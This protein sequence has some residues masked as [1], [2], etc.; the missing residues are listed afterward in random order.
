MCIENKNIEE[1]EEN[2]MQWLIDEIKAGH[3]KFI[4]ASTHR[5]H[6]AISCP[7]GYGKSGLIFCDMLY[8]IIQSIEKQ[9]KLILNLCTPIIKLCAQQGVDFIEL[10]EGV[11]NYYN[12]DKEKIR[13]F[14]NNSADA[15]KIYQIDDESIFNEY[16]YGCYPFEKLNSYFIND[17]NCDIAIIISCNRSMDKFINKFNNFTPLNTTIVTYIDEAHTISVNIDND[18]TDRID[19]ERLCGICSNLYLISATNRQ[20]LVKMVNSF[21][22]VNDDS[23]IHL[24]T[25]AEAIQKNIIC[26]PIIGFNKVKDGI[27]TIATCKS[28]MNQVRNA[29]NKIHHKILITCRDTKHLIEL[30]KQLINSGYKVFST[31]YKDG[32][33]M[34]DV[35]LQDDTHEFDNIKNFIDAIKD[36][37]DHCFILH[38]KQMISGIDIPCITDAIISKNDTDNENSY[39]TII[40]TIGRCLRLGDERTHPIEE[41][42]KKC[43]NI[44]FVTD[45]NNNKVNENLS[46]FFLAYY[47]AN[48]IRFTQ[49]F[50]KVKNSTADSTKLDLYHK[51]KTLLG[52]QNY[53]YN[54]L[55]LNIEEYIKEC[56][57]HKE[58]CENINRN[59]MDIMYSEDMKYIQ[60][61]YIELNIGKIYLTKYLENKK[62]RSD[63][64]KL[65]KKYGII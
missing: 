52:D 20:E 8:H 51:E 63:I 39:I 34:S 31:S 62:L 57:A 7:T 27:I 18:D 37:N 36:L 50:A 54:E 58:F 16:D 3:S 43:A 47:E 60:E 46:K 23:Y 6:G 30:R 45:L 21:N 15:D 17:T 19:L 2:K 56:K 29:N 49:D 64:Q 22:G 13:I 1:K 25:P 26:S 14:N 41:R 32:M 28:F 24:V 65:F 5:S 12:I 35:K 10:L 38:I 53:Y 40:Q 42:N 9:E 55:L 44:L 59:Y 48:N 61:N 33:N 4:I 11:R